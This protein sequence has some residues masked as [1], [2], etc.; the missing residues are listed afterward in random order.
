MS[1]YIQGVTDF[2]PQI[3]EFQP[4]FN[5]Y[6]KSLQ[7]SQSKYDANHD[8]LSN[9]Y[10]SM[11]NSPMLREKNIE[12][13][14]SFFKVI[15]QDI[16]K[17]ASMDLS[18]QQNVDEAASIFNQML[19]NKNIVKD[20]VWTKNWQ[21]EHQ[22]ADGF[23][24]CVDPKKCGGAWWEEGVTALN[25]MA[26][27]F[28]NATDEQAMGFG[29]ARFT[30]YQ[31]V[32]GKA[33]A[34]AKEADLSIKVDQRSGG[35][36]V[37][38]KNGENLAKPL[39]SLF[40]GT[41]GK[42]PA[43]MDYY[44]TKA[45]V[46][47][48]NAIN[49][50]I[51]TYGS[52]EAAA[53]EYI[54]QLTQNVS[55][56]LNKTEETLLYNQSQLAQQKKNIEK[57]IMDNGTTAD[58]SLADV[59]RRLISTEQQLNSSVEVIQD[60]TGNMKVGLSNA[61]KNALYNLDNALANS[62]LQTDIAGAANTLAYKDYER[63]MA[64]DPYAMESVKQANRLIL[65]DNDF[66]YKGAL[67]EFK[68]NLKQLD[69]KIDARGDNL[70]NTGLLVDAGP[71]STTV[72]LSPDAVYEQLDEQRKKLD[73][74]I[75]KSEKDLLISAMTL[76]TTAS[77]NND[78]SAN[79]DLL[80]MGEVLVTTMKGSDAAYMNKWKNYSQEAK[81]KALK[82]IDFANEF[83]KLPGAVADE[84]YD[85]VLA[86]M[87]DPSNKNNAVTRSY[88]SQ[89]WTSAD[90]IEKKN[91]IAAKSATLNNL[92]KYYRGQVS[93]VKARIKTD[94]SFD[95]Y[96]DAIDAFV[97]ENGNPKS[98]KDFA[99]EY[100]KKVVQ[101]L[102]AD[103][104]TAHGIYSKTKKQYAI[105]AYMEGTE[106]YDNMNDDEGVMSKWKEAF[107][108]HSVALGQTNVLHGGGSSAV[109]KALNFPTVNPSNY[110]S[111]A[112]MGVNT[113]IN[114]IR[115]A[116]LEQARVVM[117]GLSA[118]IPEKN[119]ES[120]LAILNQ[121]QSDF[122]TRNKKDDNGKPILNVTYQNIAGGSNDWTAL[123]IK[124][125]DGYVKQYIGTKDN[126]GVF[127][128]RREELQKEGLTLYLKKDAST[129]AFYKNAKATDVD[130]IM[131]YNGQYLIN[132]HPEIS[133]NT[134]I[135]RTDAGTH[136][137][138]GSLAFG[139]DERGNTLFKPFTLPYDD[140]QTNVNTIIEQFRREVLNPTVA[141]I[142]YKKALY[143]ITHGIKNPNELLNQ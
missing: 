45:Y 56:E 41:L 89:L 13:R 67:E 106:L 103:I 66:K 42:D 95:E 54:K 125:N 49:S 31:D 33:I 109:Q 128:D 46:T 93:S 34:L 92:D 53:T 15:D 64:V 75:S 23:R 20:M 136:M 114:D 7:M 62:F 133:K 113:Y 69:K 141:D 123:N 9:L 50:M 58:S 111:L 107:S 99:K 40:M 117:G 127:Y 55:P 21:K 100:A 120:A 119:S 94:S 37:T 52:E 14:D 57:E 110:Q 116:D 96:R 142:E 91:R 32:M 25:Y 115:Q 1:T 102:P 17:M 135:K 74:E 79:A 44:K 77:N 130:V 90:A 98:R 73:N 85:A 139:L 4:D 26:D 48:K 80:S 38:T 101:N 132:E 97:D 43:I 129:N 83:Q 134:V 122:R 27:E 28:K 61:S 88:M 104:E 22:R 35:F 18:K 59:Y 131:D 51:G 65:A 78:V 71:G 121:L 138:S 108:K 81:I 36:I 8:K 137:I 29:N 39:F 24:N 68:F 2:I 16:K 140:S 6:A 60:A 86:P 105:D 47:R 10:G 11:L 63:T 3:Q 84:M 143:N 76:A 70:D 12:A 87:I 30:P 124:V 82:S 126:P 112:N 5:F 72:N 118:G 19:D